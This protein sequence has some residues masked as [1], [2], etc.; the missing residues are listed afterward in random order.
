A[1]DK[2][3]E[4]QLKWCLSK[5]KN[6]RRAVQKPEPWELVDDA[7]DRYKVRFTWKE[8]QTVPVFDSQG[9]LIKDKLDVRSGST[10][11]LNFYQKPYILPDNSYGT[12][13]KLNAVQLVTITAGAGVDTGTM[14][15]EDLAAAFGKCDG[16][17]ANDPNVTPSAE[18]DEDF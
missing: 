14:S 1:L 3:R 17:T 8:D 7:N 18:P 10:V 12:S 16:F 13:I 6:P 9:V 5:V 4:E 11:K 15:V 2:E